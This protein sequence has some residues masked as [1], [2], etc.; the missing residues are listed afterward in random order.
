MRDLEKNPIV[1]ALLDAC[2]YDEHGLAP[3]KENPALQVAKECANCKHFSHLHLYCS[4]RR[5]RCD[6]N[7]YCGK[8]EQ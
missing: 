4:E 1:R 5:E 3:K 6:Q 8:F 2:G 7:G